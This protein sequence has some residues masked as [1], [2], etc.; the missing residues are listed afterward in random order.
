MTDAHLLKRVSYPLNEMTDAIEDEGDHTEAD[1]ANNEH[2]RRRRRSQ[3]DVALA[4]R[5]LVEI[6]KA[7]AA[8][9]DADTA[10]A[11]LSGALGSG[12]AATAGEAAAA[13]AAAA[14]RGRHQPNGQRTL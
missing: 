7:V 5:N 13:V 12:D 1:E 2:P 11:V 6:G 9:G 14:S 8:S 4:D 10:E 3:R